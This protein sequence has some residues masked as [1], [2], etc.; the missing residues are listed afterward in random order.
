MDKA[1]LRRKSARIQ[2]EILYDEIKAATVII[3]LPF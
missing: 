2:G 1:I 3:F